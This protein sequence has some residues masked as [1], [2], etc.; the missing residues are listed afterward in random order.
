MNIKI[1]EKLPDLKICSGRKIQ[2]TCPMLQNNIVV[3]MLL[4]SFSL[5]VDQCTEN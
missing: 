5:L 2:F 4:E 3:L 1:N